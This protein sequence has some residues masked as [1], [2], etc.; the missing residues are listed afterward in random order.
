MNDS[1][2]VSADRV[3]ALMVNKEYMDKIKAN[4][5]VCKCGFENLAIMRKTK[6]GVEEYILPKKC[7]IC[8]KSLVKSQTGGSIA[9]KSK[10]AKKRKSATKKTQN[11]TQK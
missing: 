7:R 9:K 4:S 5:I 10:K 2:L 1:L 6:D 11:K 8:N 3:A